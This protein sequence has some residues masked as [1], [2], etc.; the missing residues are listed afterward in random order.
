MPKIDTFPQVIFV[1]VQEDGKD[2]WLSAN[3]TKV[4][5]LGEAASEIVGT[6]QFVAAE[7]ASKGPIV[8]KR[9]KNRRTK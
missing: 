1:T 5:A 7:E 2:D 8:S 4:G 3:L 9:L 6:Y